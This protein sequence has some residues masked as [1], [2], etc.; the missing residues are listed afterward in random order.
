MATDL[1][2]IQRNIHKFSLKPKQQA[3]GSKSKQQNFDRLANRLGSLKSPK[4]L[5]TTLDYKV[6]PILASMHHST[7]KST[8]CFSSATT[9]TT[10]YANNCTLKKLFVFVPLNSTCEFRIIH[11]CIRTLK[12]SH[13]HFEGHPLVPHTHTHACVWDGE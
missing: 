8:L 5:F 12:C 13:L 1:G 6:G 4:R 9:T 11:I 10:V 2:F 3:R 7:A